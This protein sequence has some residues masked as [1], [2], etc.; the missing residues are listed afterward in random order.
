MDVISLA[1]ARQ[2]PGV[3]HVRGGGKH[4]SCLFES[5]SLR[6]LQVR[7][8]WVTTRHGTDSDRLLNH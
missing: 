3:D 8:L 7:S 5:P 4:V 6:D 2:L 1:D